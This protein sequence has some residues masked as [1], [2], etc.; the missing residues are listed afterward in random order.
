MS[1]IQGWGDVYYF[2]GEKLEYCTCDMRWNLQGWSKAF[3]LW[4]FI[5]SAAVA[6]QKLCIHAGLKGLLP[7]KAIQK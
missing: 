1:C 2:C 7:G 3:I 5:L 6:A 4:N